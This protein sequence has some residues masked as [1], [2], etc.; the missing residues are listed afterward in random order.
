MRIDLLTS[1][2]EPNH[3]KE[4]TKGVANQTG[5]SLVYRDI[6]NYTESCFKTGL[7]ALDQSGHTCICGCESVTM[8]QSNRYSKVRV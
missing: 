5:F 7:H 4:K 8:P 1:P 3:S 6:F 2:E